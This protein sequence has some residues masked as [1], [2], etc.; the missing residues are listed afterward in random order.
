MFELWRNIP[1]YE[2]LYQVSN[3]GNVH[4]KDRIVVDD[5]RGTVRSRRLRGKVIRTR[6][7][8][9][10]G[11]LAVGL[12]T[13]NRNKRTW[14]VHQLVLLAFV[15]KCPT[16][17]E[18]RHIDGQAWNNRLDNL[19]YGT[20]T[21]NEHDKIEHGTKIYG[22]RNGQ[23]KLLETQVLEIKSRLVL[24]EDYKALAVEFD[25]HLM[26]IWRIKKEKNWFYLA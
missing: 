11:H 18:I 5:Y 23:S 24:G 16:G 14:S 8:D 19:V 3:F 21:E 4:S 15:G 13:Q 20:H 1:G 6:M 26:T 9:N 7:Y 12:S 25:V 17:L 2:D 10:Y 22:E